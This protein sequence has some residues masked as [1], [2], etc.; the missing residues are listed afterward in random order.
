MVLVTTGIE[1]GGQVRPQG[2]TLSIEGNPVTDR[3]R[4]SYELSHRGPVRCLVYDAAGML[5]DELLDG[6]QEPGRHSLSWSA[7]GAAPG[8]YFVQVQAEGA[9]STARLVKTR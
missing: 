2:P 1:E 5:V 4:I 3:A 7:V 6:V 8:L 9:T